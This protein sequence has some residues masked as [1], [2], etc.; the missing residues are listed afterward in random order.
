MSS[1]VRPLYSPEKYFERSS[2]QAAHQQSIIPHHHGWSNWHRGKPL[3]RP[4]SL[5]KVWPLKRVTS[6]S[7]VA[8]WEPIP[9]ENVMSDLYQSLSHS[10]WDCKYH[11]VF[12]SQ[13]A[14]AGCSSC[15]SNAWDLLTPP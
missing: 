5:E 9:K 4:V 2:V 13:E 10:K 8:W 7:K 14:T 11:V 12:R 3:V 6:S 15:R 1:I